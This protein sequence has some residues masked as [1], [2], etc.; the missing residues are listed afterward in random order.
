MP[1]PS[2]R[3]R[4]SAGPGRLTLSEIAALSGVCVRT[5]RRRL[6]PN[7]DAAVRQFWV[8]AL[9][10]RKRE[11]GRLGLIHGDATLVRKHLPTISGVDAPL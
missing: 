11:T 6:I 4:R 1:T 9:D 8:H 2:P 3:R 10:L 7:D 5:L